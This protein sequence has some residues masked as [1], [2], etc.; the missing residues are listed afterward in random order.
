MRQQQAGGHYVTIYSWPGNYPVRVWE[1]AM[2]RTSDLFLDCVFYIFN[3]REAAE[4]NDIGVGGT[5]FLAGAALENN[6]NHFHFYLVTAAHVIQKA[7]TPFVKFNKRGSGVEIL[8]LPAARWRQHP[9]GDDVSVCHVVIPTLL[10]RTMGIETE[11]FV[12]LDSIGS[13]DIGIGDDIFMVG[14]FAQH[15]GNATQNIPALRFGNIA[16][17]PREPIITA[18]G[19]RQESFLVEC[20]SVPG[21]SGSPVFVYKSD[22]ERHKRVNPLQVI[23]DRFWLLGIDWCH[24]SDVAQVR[25]EETGAEESSFVRV[26]TGMAGVIPAWK[27]LEAINQDEFAEERRKADEQL[28]KDRRN[29]PAQED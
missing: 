27:I 10:F 14:R 17:M 1:P 6:P 28:T 9:H 24:L 4:S 2:P 18:D 23:S 3:S 21:Y 22:F 12:S 13:Q 11:R 25:D 20:R 15:S 8:D 29:S 16:A 26:N 19:R 7:K 5:G